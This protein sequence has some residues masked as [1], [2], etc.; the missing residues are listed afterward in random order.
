M[1]L[2][3]FLAIVANQ[4]FLICAYSIFPIIL[5]VNK[6]SEMINNNKIS[7]VKWRSLCFKYQ[8][9]TGMQPIS[10]HLLTSPMVKSRPPRV[11]HELLSLGRKFSNRKCSSYTGE[12]LTT[13]YWPTLA[14]SE[15]EPEPRILF[16]VNFCDWR[17]IFLTKNVLATSRN[18]LEPRSSHLNYPPLLIPQFKFSANNWVQKWV[19]RWKLFSLVSRTI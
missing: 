4:L 2:D 12:Q 19:L 6:P 8:F 7:M 10:P 17:K 3:H 16:Y 9:Q 1:K 18:H 5:K 15:G 11:S 14:S 13:A